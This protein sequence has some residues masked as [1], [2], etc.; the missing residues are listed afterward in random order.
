M[1]VIGPVQSH[2]H[3]GAVTLTLNLPKNPCVEMN[4]CTKRSFR[5]NKYWKKN[6]GLDTHKTKYTPCLLVT[7]TN[8]KGKGSGFV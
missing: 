8:V 3:D 1:S 6:I 5:T 4:P 7:Q 2:Y